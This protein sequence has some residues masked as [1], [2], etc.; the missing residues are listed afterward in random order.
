MSVTLSPLQCSPLSPPEPG[1]YWDFPRAIE[2]WRN[3][4]TEGCWEDKRKKKRY[5]NIERE[6]ER[7]KEFSCLGV[8]GSDE[9]H[10]KR[11]QLTPGSGT[12][13]DMSLSKPDPR[14]S[15]WSP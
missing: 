1:Q 11:M 8:R 2:L 5:P 10:S 9:T 14:P 3:C 12:M 7:S 4:W 13:N 15:S 6:Q